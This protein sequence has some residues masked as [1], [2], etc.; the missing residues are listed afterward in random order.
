MHGPGA[1]E[2]LECALLEHPQQLGLQL[3]RQV[4]D[5]VE[6]QRAAVGQLEAARPSRRDGAGE[7]A[8]LVAEQLALE[9]AGGQRGAVDV[10]K[11]CGRRG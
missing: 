3:E 7:G 6:E 8:L 2:P 10:T 5:L 11:A 4:A 9:Q 1:A